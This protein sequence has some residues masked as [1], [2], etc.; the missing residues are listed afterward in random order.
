MNI[1]GKY[2][3][4][5]LGILSL[6][7][8]VYTANL[9][10]NAAGSNKLVQKKVE[11]ENSKEGIWKRVIEDVVVGAVVGAV[12]YYALKSSDN[13]IN[14]IPNLGN[15]CYLNALIQQLY[16][17]K[18]FRERI[19]RDNSDDKKITAL[20][21]IFLLLDKGEAI[22]KSDIEKFILDLGYKGTQEDAAEFLIIEEGLGKLLEKYGLGAM[23]SEPLNIK[24]VPNRTALTELLN[25]GGKLDTNL[26]HSKIRELKPETRDWTD[27]DERWR[28]ERTAFLESTENK[29]DWK[30]HGP[31]LFRPAGGQ[32]GVIVNRTLSNYDKKK[33][34]L[35]T[36]KIRKVISV[37]D[38]MLKNGVTYYLTGATVHEGRSMNSGH[39]YSYKKNSKGEWMRYNDSRVSIESDKDVMKDMESNGILF[40][41]TA[42][43]QR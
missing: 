16:S 13:S 29:E 9:D 5:I 19:M 34:R 33:K 15:S 37:P 38:R 43:P 20:K 11:K 3:S 12:V 35:T 2:F 41:Y 42:L 17:I 24:E 1:F 18:S 36:S 21:S 40:I 28:T 14:G 39:Y 27:H 4:G 7:P 23:F 10:V 22:K 6:V 32:F 30:F 25:H 26:V 31:C 8:L